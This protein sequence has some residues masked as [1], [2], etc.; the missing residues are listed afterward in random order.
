MDLDRFFDVLRLDEASPAL[1]GDIIVTEALARRAARLSPGMV[2]VAGTLALVMG[3]GAGFGGAEPTA[4]RATL[5]PL[6]YSPSS[7]LLGG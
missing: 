1:D 3:V 5:T 6:A 4:A 7:V 2:A